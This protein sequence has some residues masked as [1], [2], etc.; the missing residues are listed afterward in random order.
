M[1]SKPVAFKDVFIERPSKVNS[2]TLFPF[3]RRGFGAM[4]FKGLL[5]LLLIVIKMFL[6]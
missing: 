4:L 6:R 3:W 5:M 1:T 2:V